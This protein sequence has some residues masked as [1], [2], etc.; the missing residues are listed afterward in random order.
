HSTSRVKCST[1]SGR[2]IGVWCLV[3]GV[4][5]SAFSVLYSRSSGDGDDGNGLRS[6]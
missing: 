4:Q 1:V 3:P 2:R 5:R 6:I